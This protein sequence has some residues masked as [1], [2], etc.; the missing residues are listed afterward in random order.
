MAVVLTVLGSGIYGIEPAEGV[1]YV[2]YYGDDDGFGFG[3][4]LVS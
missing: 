3:T 2:T 1:S 4:L